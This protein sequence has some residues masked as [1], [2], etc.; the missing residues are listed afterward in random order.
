MNLGCIFVLV[1]FALSA[2]GMGWLLW[3][4]LSFLAARGVPPGVVVT[5]AVFAFA[6]YSLYRAR[7]DGML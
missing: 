1:L 5:G 4:L 2:L 7:R 3:L 6:M